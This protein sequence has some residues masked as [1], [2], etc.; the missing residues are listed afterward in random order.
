MTLGR[1]PNL[2]NQS[3]RA[4]KELVREEQAGRQQ[5]NRVRRRL[6]KIAPGSSAGAQ[7]Q[8]A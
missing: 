4:P 7:N 3:L 1:P 2:A 6:P 5:M 8:I